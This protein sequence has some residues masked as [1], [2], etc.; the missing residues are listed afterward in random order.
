L[1]AVVV[2]AGALEIGFG[3]AE[4]SADVNVS[5]GHFALGLLKSKRVIHIVFD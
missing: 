3:F 1:V 4:I 2:L 5:F